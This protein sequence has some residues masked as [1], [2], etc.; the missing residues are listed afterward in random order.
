MKIHKA[1][2]RTVFPR[3]RKHLFN[4][5]VFISFMT[6]F[7]ISPA[8]KSYGGKPKPTQQDCFCCWQGPN[9][10][11]GY[12]VGATHSV[13]TCGDLMPLRLTII[14][15]QNLPDHYWFACGEI[16]VVT[17]ASTG[18][19]APAPTTL[20]PRLC[21]DAWNQMDHSTPHPSPD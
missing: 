12:A 13:Q 20:I 9:G 6:L 1:S 10:P 5:L 15:E 16:P 2:L 4:F 3:Q 11:D 7:V 17:I 18:L 19:P 21:N 8:R 14:G